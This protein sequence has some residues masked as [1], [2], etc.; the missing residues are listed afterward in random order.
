MLR[1]ISHTTQTS[2]ARPAHAASAAAV[3]TARR[4]VA[5]SARRSAPSLSVAPEAAADV[6]VAAVPSAA[7]AA[8]AASAAS[9]SAAATPLRSSL[10]PRLLAL[11]ADIA[12]NSKPKQNP[13]TGYWNAPKLNAQMLARLRKT[14][15]FS[16]GVASQFERVRLRR[17]EP[18]VLKG[19]KREKE[20]I[21]R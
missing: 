11:S 4:C 6:A 9:P 5:T 16:G 17:V 19:K 20:L 21:D 1:I 8:A 18:V 15:L 13:R 2:T 14:D 7:I 10:S 3:L 12:G